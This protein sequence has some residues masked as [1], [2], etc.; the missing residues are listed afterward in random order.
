[1]GGGAGPLRLEAACAVRESEDDPSSLDILRKARG[2][3][4]RLGGDGLEAIV[5]ITSSGA[6]LRSFSTCGRNSGSLSK[7]IRS[8]IIGVTPE[9][10]G[11]S[12]CRLEGNGGLVVS[13]GAS[14]PGDRPSLLFIRFLRGDLTPPPLRGPIEESKNPLLG[15]V[16]TSR[17]KTPNTL[18]GFARTISVYSSRSASPLSPTKM[19]RLSGKSDMIRFRVPFLRSATGSKIPCNMPVYCFR[20]NDPVGRPARAKKLTSTG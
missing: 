12:V 4:G 7:S 2:L 18:P 11:A 14:L 16:V 5:D 8:P 13:E 17:I 19:K 20:W 10:A 9:Y 6:A 1:M 3:D 15:M